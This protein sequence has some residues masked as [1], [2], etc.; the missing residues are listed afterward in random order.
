M[1]WLRKM[2]DFLFGWKVTKINEEKKSDDVMQERMHCIRF[3]TE[4]GEQLAVL[5]TTDEFETGIRR[6][7][8]TIDTMP[9]DTADVEKDERVP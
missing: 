5:L 3:M 1:N 9:I 8:D 6:W 7:I 4:R 2:F